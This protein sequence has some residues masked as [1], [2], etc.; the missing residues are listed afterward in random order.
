M[1]KQL[2][3]IAL[4]VIIGAAPTWYIMHKRQAAFENA[5]EQAGKEAEA[6]SAATDESNRLAKKASDHEYETRIATLRTESKR[7]LE[8][9]SGS[10][11]VPTETGTT[12]GSGDLVCFDREKLNAAIGRLDAGL[13]GIVEESDG[14]KERLNSV[15]SWWDSVVY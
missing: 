11:Y 7:L 8:S 12:A 1:N 15:K 2:V 9:R 5:V 10:G 6:R 14:Q 3:I 4:S 13:S